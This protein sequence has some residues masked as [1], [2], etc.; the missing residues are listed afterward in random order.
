VV[1]LQAVAHAPGGPYIRV[2]PDS[3]V[4]AARDVGYDAVVE[5]LFS[6][7]VEQDRELRGVRL[8]MESL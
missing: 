2:L 5:Q 1:E 3:A 8:I 4:S 7:C 6:V